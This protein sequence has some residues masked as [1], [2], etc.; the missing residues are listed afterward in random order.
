MKHVEST[1]WWELLFL[2]SAVA[3]VAFEIVPTWAGLLMFL[4]SVWWGSVTTSL[5]GKWLTEVSEVVAGLVPK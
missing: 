5:L 4:P 3:L 2:M 1:Q